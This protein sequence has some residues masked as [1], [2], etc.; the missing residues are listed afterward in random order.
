MTKAAQ[1]HDLI[2]SLPSGYLTQVGSRGTALSGG[3]KQR[4]AIARAMAQTDAEVLLLDEATSALDSGCEALILDALK[5]VREKKTVVAV[6][7]V[8]FFLSYFCY[9]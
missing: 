4:L 8:S 1:I 9:I 2:I 3:Q 7:H 6:A 5:N